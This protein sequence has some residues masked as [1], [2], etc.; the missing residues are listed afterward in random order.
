[1]FRLSCWSLA[2]DHVL[3]ISAAAAII[4]EPDGV[5]GSHVIIYK[6]PRSFEREDCEYGPWQQWQKWWDRSDEV[7]A[8]Q[9][10]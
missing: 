2:S 4:A 3:A 6:W 9:T 8:W 10:T 1:M 7:L 5:E